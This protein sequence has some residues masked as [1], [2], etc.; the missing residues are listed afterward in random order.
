MLSDD[1]EQLFKFKYEYYVTNLP[2]ESQ[3]QLRIAPTQVKRVCI[4]I[5][6]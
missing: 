5:L 3:F 4:H 6:L 1:L 2:Y